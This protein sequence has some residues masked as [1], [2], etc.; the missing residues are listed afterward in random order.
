MSIQSPSESETNSRIPDP[1]VVGTI[2]L[3][4]YTIVEVLPSENGA[5][6]YRVAEI[7]ACPHCGVENE[8]NLN[9]CGFCGTEL[10]AP[11]T[12]GLTERPTPANG[13]IIP[14]GFA[15]SGMSYA[16]VVEAENTR[17]MP[18]RMPTWSYS[19]LSDPGIARAL[20]GDPNEDSVLA[21]KVSSQHAKISQE[22]GIML[23]ADGVGGAEAGEVASELAAQTIAQGLVAALLA[24][25]DGEP[26]L[27]EDIHETLRAA[28]AEANQQVIEYGQSHALSLGTTVVVA[29][30]YGGRLYLANVGDS[31]AYWMR[32]SELTQITHDHSYV[33]ELEAKGDITAEQ[34][35]RHPQRNLILRSLGDPSGFEVDVFPNKGRILE[36]QAGDKIL[37]CSDGLWE[38]VDDQAI[39]AV[40]ALPLDAAQACAQLV[41]MANAAGGVD[42][43]S[44]LIVQMADG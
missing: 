39:T 6:L 41:S 11:R 37:L 33:A 35:R 5:N 9:H 26:F 10:P 31:R 27:E 4:R 13:E 1:L 15:L 19:F 22:L 40:L 36:P 7:R 44:V 17:D 8:G 28:I 20:R 14:T 16:F 18:R 30:L 34:A 29:L 24:P 21:L 43:I 12:L 3:D 38:M 32:G 25:T 42:N 23:I 2:L